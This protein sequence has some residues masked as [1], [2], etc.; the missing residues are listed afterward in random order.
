M[1]LSSATPY[2]KS[3]AFCDST[4]P[5]IRAAENMFSDICRFLEVPTVLASQSLRRFKSTTYGCLELANIN[6]LAQR[7]SSNPS[8]IKRDRSEQ[9][10]NPEE[11]PKKLQKIGN[12]E[13]SK[14]S[15]FR[16]FLREMEDFAERLRRS[17]HDESLQQLS[18][19][20]MNAATAIKNEA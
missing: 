11:S 17:S 10:T 3:E 19:P 14:T 7:F 13:S 16:E 4:A 12:R 15:Q 2:I 8:N 6:D 18:S 1:H 20:C 9:Q 5:E